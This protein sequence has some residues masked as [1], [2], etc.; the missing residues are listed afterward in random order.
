MSVWVLLVAGETATPWRG[1]TAIRINIEKIDVVEAFCGAV[2]NVCASSL[3]GYDAGQLRV[4]WRGL[5]LRADA[6]LPYPCGLSMDDPIHVSV[7][8]PFS[9]QQPAGNDQTSISVLLYLSGVLPYAV[10]CWV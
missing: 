9:E 4:R 2:K 6:P 10:N 5:S 7:P 1:F 8:E 3:A